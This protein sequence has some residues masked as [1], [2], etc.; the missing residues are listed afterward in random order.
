MF[1]V[2]VGP[3]HESRHSLSGPSSWPDVGDRLPDHSTQFD[4]MHSKS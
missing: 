3:A 1:Y 4:H 2:T